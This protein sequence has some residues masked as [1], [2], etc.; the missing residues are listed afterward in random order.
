MSDQ[1]YTNVLNKL[2][3][4]DRLCSH[5]KKDAIIYKDMLKDT[6]DTSSLLTERSFGPFKELVTEG[7]DDESLWEEIQTKNRPAIRYIKNK[8]VK[9]SKK[10]NSNKE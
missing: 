5:S 9:I 7:M 4:I 3:D 10:L 1:T 2:E 8:V 6:F